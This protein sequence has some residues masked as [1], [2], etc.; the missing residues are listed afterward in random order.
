MQWG[1]VIQEVDF[2][3]FYYFIAIQGFYV[4]LT[5]GSIPQLYRRTREIRLER[6]DLLVN[7]SYMPKVTLLVP[8]LNEEQQIVFNLQNLLKLPY[9]HKE[10]IVINDGSKDATMKMLQDS[11]QLAKVPEITPRAQLK[12]AQV[13][14]YWRSRLWPN[15]LVID[16]EN[17]GKA[18]A[19]NAGLNCCYSSLFIALDA[20]T[21][22]TQEALSVIV[23]AFLA[24]PNT[25]AIGSAI[26]VANGCIFRNNRMVQ[27]LFPDR[28][29]PAIQVLE[30]MRAFLFGRVGWNPLGGNLIIS[31]A[32]G[33][34]DA[35]TVIGSG[36]YS[37]DTV[38]ED[39][40]L[41]VRLHRY[42]RERQI[43]Y[44]IRSIPDPLA[45]TEVPVN[46]KT[47]SK[48]R[49]RWQRGLWQVLWKHRAVFFKKRYGK[50]G[51]ISLPCFF[52]I[53]ALSPFVEFFGGLF[54]LL[55]FF[56]GV[57]DVLFMILF[58]AVLYGVGILSSCLAVLLEERSF[59]CYQNVPSLLKMV[60]YAMMEQVGYRHRTVWWR[61]KGFHNW[62]RHK[63]SWNKFKRAG[64]YTRG[65]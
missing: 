60:A 32:F 13:R 62:L 42:L 8:C 27:I 40:E 30:Y 38:T 58:I 52:F 26:G 63:E 18:D 24:Q 15:L 48:Q 39:L 11:F 22:V 28:F 2:Y 25:F 12:T 45:W 3:V 14:G 43:P 50:L 57:V 34:F 20:D 31:G 23:K 19:L 37:T 5:I 61:L 53:D 47:L 46:Y 54:V 29:V 9:Q 59:G 49:E 56:M 33:L 55:G 6:F 44:C 1:H 7:S 51:W 16:K 41:V 64:I 36:G 21:L 17:G 4:I 35:E 65:R 10:I